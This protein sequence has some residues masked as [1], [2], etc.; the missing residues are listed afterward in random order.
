[1]KTVITPLITIKPKK[2]ESA[3][4]YLCD[5]EEVIYASKAHLNYPP[6]HNL[7]DEDCYV[8]LTY[9]FIY[10]FVKEDKEMKL[11]QQICTLGCQGIKFL[12]EEG[13]QPAISITTNSENSVFTIL[14]GENMEILYQYLY[15][16]IYIISGGLYSH[17]SLPELNPKIP[18]KFFSIQFCLYKR[19]LYFIHLDMKQEKISN[20]K[21]ER[22]E[23]FNNPNILFNRQLLIDQSFHPGM[24]SE[25]YGKSIGFEPRLLVVVFLNYNE[26]FMTFFESILLHSRS[27][28]QIKFTNYNS[29]APIF[30]FEKVEGMSIEKFQ[31]ANSN[32]SLVENFMNGFINSK[33]EVKKIKLASIIM[34]QTDLLNLFDDLNKISS[35][36]NLISFALFDLKFT[37]FPVNVFS[38]FLRAH[39]KIEAIFLSEVNVEGSTVLNEICNSCKSIYEIHL[40]RL[41]FDQNLSSTINLPNNTVL[42]DFSHSQFKNPTL[43]NV[44]EF[45]NSSNCNSNGLMVDM[46]SLQPSNIVFFNAYKALAS[47]SLSSNI[48]EVNWSNNPMCPDLIKFFMSQK[49]LTYITIKDLN[50]THQA[51]FFKML[52]Y[53]IRHKP[54]IKGL[55][56]G[57]D[58]FDQDSFVFFI[59]SLNNSTNL[60]SFKLHC[61]QGQNKVG[62][63]ADLIESLEN[64][65][66]TAVDIKKLDPE[67]FL[68]IQNAVLANDSIESC[69]LTWCDVGKENPKFNQMTG[70]MKRILKLKPASSMEQRVFNAITKK[71][72][73]VLKMEK[74]FEENDF[75]EE[76]EF[77]E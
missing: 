51:P 28:V 76:E 47:K 32:F 71:K 17:F 69:S 46:S 52:S 25:Y 22:S 37:E 59:Q 74:A 45:L 41:K 18:M 61:Q 68:K 48:C 27:I 40:N 38:Q 4:R 11:R 26:E 1:M 13:M 42:V 57:S 55:E 64:L 60:Q 39:D 15:Y 62:E 53:F 50:I 56:I 63:A 77:K 33:C 36:K 58:S 2:I 23:Y 34:Q 7:P 35:F 3:S 5:L 29:S 44:L 70:L 73:S 49:Q 21:I 20:S 67:V 31:L 10:L 8:I 54:E 12:N 30:N 16:T 6:D 19:S 24:F 65:K 66:E 75:Y 14:N 9:G 72:E 43:Q